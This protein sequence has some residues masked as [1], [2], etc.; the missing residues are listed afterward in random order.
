MTNSKIQTVYI[1]IDPGTK[2]GFSAYDKGIKKL[3]DV[4]T[5]AIHEAFELVKEY[6]LA[7]KIHVRVEDA[8]KRKWFGANAAAKMQGAGSVKRDCSAWQK[9]LEKNKIPFDMPAPGK[10]K[11]KV[12]K[13]YFKMLT[14][15][16]KIC[17][18]HARDSAM[19]V[20]GM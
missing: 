11:T 16:D 18:E 6:H 17:S 19:L 13:E 3:I 15:W 20:F 7:G 12:S 8:R 1:G 5:L 10:S 4:R 14:G 2:T 9:F